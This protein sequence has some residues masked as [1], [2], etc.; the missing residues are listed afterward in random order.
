MVP[1]LWGKSA[2]ARELSSENLAHLTTW[3]Y[4]AVFSCYATC[5]A[6]FIF[7]YKTTQLGLLLIL[8]QLEMHTVADEIVSLLAHHQ[9]PLSSF[10]IITLN[11]KWWK[12]PGNLARV[13]FQSVAVRYGLFKSTG[14]LVKA[15][16]RPFSL[17]LSRWSAPPCWATSTWRATRSASR[18]KPLPT[19]RLWKVGRRTERNWTEV[20]GFNIKSSNLGLHFWCL[21]TDFQNHT[22]TGLTFL[23]RKMMTPFVAL[24]TNSN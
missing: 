22:S 15:L 12:N 19:L 17:A 23:A 20:K 18:W 8:L 7:N 11:S 10:G 5:S 1:S 4:L 16:L 14:T 3:F 24:L 21:N 2:Q 13:I 9:W 6:F